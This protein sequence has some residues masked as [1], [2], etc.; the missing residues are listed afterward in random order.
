MNFPCNFLVVALISMQGVAQARPDAQDPQTSRGQLEMALSCHGGA[1][2]HELISWISNLGGGPIMDSARS[3]TGAEYTIPNP[4]YVLGFPATRF[5]IRSFRGQDRD[6][7]VYETVFTDKS[8]RSIASIA[9]LSPDVAGNYERRVGNNHLFLRQQG[10]VTYVTCAMGVHGPG[11]AQALHAP[12]T[13]AP[14]SNM[15]SQDAEPR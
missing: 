4:V 9:G 10:D 3:T 13:D 8:F 7:A 11:L 5:N 15:E 1:Q 14:L 12:E 2:P 6:F